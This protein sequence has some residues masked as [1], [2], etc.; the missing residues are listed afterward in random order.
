M[1]VD[2]SKELYC[3]DKDDGKLYKINSIYFPLGSPSG[4]DISIEVEDDLLEWRSI[5]DIEIISNVGD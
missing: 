2:L 3:K 5:K 1:I 4:K